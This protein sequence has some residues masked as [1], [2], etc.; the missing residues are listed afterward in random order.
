MTYCITSLF[1]F[2]IQSTRLSFQ[3]SLK[4]YF[5][6]YF[7]TF[8][9]PFFFEVL[10]QFPNFTSLLF[11]AF[12]VKMI[13]ELNDYF[14]VGTL[15]S[16]SKMATL[17]LKTSQPS[18]RNETKQAYFLILSYFYFPWKFRFPWNFKPHMEP[19]LFLLKKNNT[20][21]WMLVKHFKKLFVT[22][23]LDLWVLSAS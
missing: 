21:V 9:K 15:K 12:Q 7:P 19:Y 1:L 17:L 5:I 23:T 4:I 16:I 8:S 22:Q 3:I 11:L 2:P 13:D 18:Q 6:F 10:N 14:I 20:L